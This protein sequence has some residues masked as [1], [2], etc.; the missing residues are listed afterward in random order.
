MKY[1]TFELEGVIEFIPTIY[2]DNRGY[3]LETFKADTIN[4]IAKK[5]FNFCQ[6][7]ESKSIYGVFRGLHYQLPPYA[8]TKLVRVVYGKILDI[9]VDI[10]IGS[11][12]FGKYITVELNDEK[13]NQLLIPRGFAHGFLV[14]SDQAIVVY[15][16]DNYYSKEHD[17]GIR[18]DDKG[19]GLKLPIAK[20]Q[21]IISEK[22]NNLPTLEELKQK[23]EL[24]FYGRDYY[25]K[26]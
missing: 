9:A 21:M 12:T 2:K 13:K 16:V 10:R 11:P 23:N 26:E 14:L 1:N 17:R 18:F 8:Q 4:D 24:F 22:D 19:I 20:D 5:K 6:D 7:N 15:K 25:G 3:F